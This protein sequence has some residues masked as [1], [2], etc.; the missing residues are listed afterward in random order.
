MR[1]LSIFVVIASL[2]AQDVPHISRPGIREFH[3]NTLDGATVSSPEILKASRAVI[4]Y[5][6]N[7]TE[8]GAKLLKFTRPKQASS[9]TTNIIVLLE[10]DTETARAFLSRFPWLS[11]ASAFLDPNREAFRALGLEATPSSIGIEAGLEQWRLTGSRHQLREL[12]LL[13][14]TWVDEAK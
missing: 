14:G 10:G 13:I 8:E 6:A 11:S 7:P 5:V 9:K 3:V 1:F 4:L 12:E 2:G